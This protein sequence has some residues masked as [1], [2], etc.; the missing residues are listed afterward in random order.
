MLYAVKCINI[1]LNSFLSAFNLVQV[2]VI[3]LGA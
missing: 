3:D 2:S 1:N